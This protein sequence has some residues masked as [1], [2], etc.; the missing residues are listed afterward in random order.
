MVCKIDDGKWAWAEI[1]RKLLAD[2]VVTGNG[3]ITYGQLYDEMAPLCGWPDRTPGHAWTK[4]LPLMN[5]AV[6]DSRF[7][8]PL[9]PALVRKDTL[10]MPIGDGFGGA[11]LECYGYTPEDPQAVADVEVYR[12]NAHFRGAR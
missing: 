6:L 2:R 11:V 8:E 1:G 9:L 12:L 5:I 4:R 3:L 7:G 10:G